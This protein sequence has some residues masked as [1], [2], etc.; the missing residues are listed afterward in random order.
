MVILIRV[1]ILKYI[2]EVI[3]NLINFSNVGTAML[4]L[5][6]VAMQDNWRTVMTDLMHYN[7]YCSEDPKYCGRPFPQ[8]YFISFMVISLQV[9]LNLFILGLID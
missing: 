7:P 3:D 6:R 5:F 2:G 1:L 9:I 8:L 4:T